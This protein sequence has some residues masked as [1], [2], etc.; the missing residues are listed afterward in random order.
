M[1]KERTFSRALLV[2]YYAATA[3]AVWYRLRQDMQVYNLLLCAAALLLPALPFALYRFTK[4]RPVPMLEIVYVGFVFFAVPFASLFGAYDF[5]PYWDKV[6]HFASGPLFA[7]LGTAVYFC[8]KPGRR[9]DRADAFN[10]AAFSWMFAMSSAVLWEIWEFIVSLVSTA[11]PQQ[12]ARTGVTDTMTD[13]LVCTI[14]GLITAISC[15]N[16]LHHGGKAPA[17]G[18][19]M[20]LFDRFYHTNIERHTSK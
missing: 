16:Y 19:M 6:L 1:Q 20:R 15:W 12:V 7:V 4:L 3:C 14:G 11:D 17:H 9:L 8:N 2:F 13:M 10:A 18:I 5:I